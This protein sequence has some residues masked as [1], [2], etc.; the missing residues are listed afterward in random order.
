MSLVKCRTLYNEIKVVP[1]DV[2]IQR[3]SVYGIILHEAKI[4]LAKASHTSKYVLPGGGIHK[5]EAIEVALIREVIEE[6]G[7]EVDVGEFLHFEADFFYYDPLDIAIHGFLFYYRC[8]PLTL[9]LPI[10]N[11]PIDEDLVS[12]SWEDVRQLTG[13]SFQSHGDTTMNLLRRCLEI[14]TSS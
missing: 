6:T 2:M 10:L 5:G 3:P 11:L 4:L 14:E 8:K 9:E 1:A 13:V 7:I 12:A